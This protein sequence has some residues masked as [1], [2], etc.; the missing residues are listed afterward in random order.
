[1]VNFSDLGLLDEIGTKTFEINGKTINVLQY[2]SVEQKNDL[3]Q[4]ALQNS[5]E[6]GIYNEVY[7]G[8]FFPLYIVMFY[9]DIE[10]TDEEKANPLATFDILVRHGII[11]KVLDLIP[12]TERNDLF[13]IYQL[14]KENNMKYMRTFGYTVNKLIN[15]M[16]AQIEDS[17][18]KIQE[19]AKDFDPSKYQAVIDFAT[20]ANG[21]RDINTNQ[22][23]E[24]KED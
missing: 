5:D 13:T 12:E 11:S 22:P 15:D 16:P 6:N 10:F 18:N 4:I 3:I 8:S 14:Q 1:M 17:I 21:G 9:T 7:A 24:K 19:I 23:I 2:L 20:A